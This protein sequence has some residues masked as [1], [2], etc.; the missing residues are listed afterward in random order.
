[1]SPQI[2]KETHTNNNG[3]EETLANIQNVK[4]NKIR[5]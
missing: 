1:M 3:K 4:I 5:I 2:F